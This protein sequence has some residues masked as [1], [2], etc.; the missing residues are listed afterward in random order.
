MWDL[1]PPTRH[2]SRTKSQLTSS[3]R[4]LP[5]SVADSKDPAVVSFACD[6]GN[7]VKVA[8]LSLGSQWHSKIWRLYDYVVLFPR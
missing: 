2:L 1:P 8:Q 4:S 7:G 6:G 5:R 3:M